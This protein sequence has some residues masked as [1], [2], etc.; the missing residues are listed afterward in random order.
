MSL[1]TVY[2]KYKMKKND[3]TIPTEIGDSDTLRGVALKL[4]LHKTAT[5]V[6][7]HELESKI[8]Q[9]ERQ[10]DRMYREQIKYLP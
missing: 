1:L 2:K 10:I 6:K 4:Q 8:M 3:Q 9:L 5:D 7:I